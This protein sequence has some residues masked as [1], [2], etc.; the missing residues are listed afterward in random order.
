MVIPVRWANPDRAAP[1]GVDKL[2]G[3]DCCLVRVCD[4]RLA[5]VDIHP[6]SSV[7]AGL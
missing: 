6:I 3:N 4:E 2:V 5:A 7:V 1:N